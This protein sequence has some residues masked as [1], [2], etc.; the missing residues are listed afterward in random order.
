MLKVDVVLPVY[1]E[2]KILEQSVEE[3]LHFL[4]KYLS[5]DWKI[6]IAEN[7]STDN[8]LIVADN[9]CGK[10]K[11]KVSLISLKEKGRGGA[12]KAAW[13][14]SEADIVSYMDVDLSSSLTSFPLLI[15]ML[16]QGN[17]ISVGSR[18]RRDSEVTRS[19]LR[20]LLSVS[21]NFIIRVLFGVRSFSD[22]QCGFKAAKRTVIL[23]LLLK[24]KSKKWFFDTGLLILAEKV[25]CKIKEI[26]VVWTQGSKTTV[27]ILSTIFED[28]TEMLRFKWFLRR[29]KD[30]R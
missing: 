3:L 25:G 26:P 4:E 8:T 11:G 9:I 17:D 12:L 2:E 7:S 20:T 27:K 13:E 28:I 6:I 1:N 24:V 14:K 15:N 18:L 30:G 16:L 19:L 29:L 5:Y 23:P 22:A 10:F 21:Y